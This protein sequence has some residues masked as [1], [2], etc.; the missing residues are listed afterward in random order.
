MR[1]FRRQTL[2]TNIGIGQRT[3]HK[4]FRVF[5]FRWKTDENILTMKIS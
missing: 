4:I 3:L 1:N 5:N 2:A